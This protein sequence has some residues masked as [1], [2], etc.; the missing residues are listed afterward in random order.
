MAA[1]TRIKILTTGVT[2][3]APS[4]LKTGELAYSYVPGTQSNNGD[5]LYIGT[6][7]ETGGIASSV[8]LIGGKYFTNLLDHVHGI[9]TASSALIVDS[10]KHLS[11]LAIGSLQLGSS[12]GSGQAVTSITTSQSLVSAD[13]TQ[14]PTALAVKS[15]VDALGAA[16]GLDIAGDSGTGNINL[17]TQ[18]FTVAGGTALT[19]SVTG[20]TATISLD[21]TA[22]TPGSYGSTTEI[23]TFT[24]DAQ[25]RLTAAGS[26]NVATNLSISDGTV[27]DTVSL[28][29]D[30]LSFLGTTNETT[31]AVTDN[32]VTIGLPNDVTIGNNLTIVGDLIVQG[33]TTTVDSTT[34]SLSDPVIELA[35]DTT[36]VASDGLDRGIR[37]KWGN[38]T[39]VKEGFFGFD[40]QSQRFVFKPDESATTDNFS[41]PWGDAE[42]GDI[43]ATG[44]DIGNITIGIVDDNTISTTS[45]N[46]VLDSATGIVDVNADLQ[47]DSLSL[48]AALPVASGGTGL[49]SLTGNAVVISNSAGTAFSFVTGTEGAIMQFNASGVPVSSNI[50]DGGTY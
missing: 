43:Y 45:G 40:I 25:G 32:T 37:F 10:N 15:Y 21:N 24:V 9:T 50:I 39:A 29:T 3:T 44:A 27:T 35:Y 12:G 14:L 28:L 36:N 46:L 11:D 30:T 13:N 23:P 1:L 38:G 49:Q 8:D 7:T 48:T 4:N 31:V 19:S 6:G 17:A 33:T 2:T 34:I 42:F 47:A 26:V 22:V 20:Q 18:T 41:A 16:L 5:R